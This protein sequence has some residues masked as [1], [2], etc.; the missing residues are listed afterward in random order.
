[1]FFNPLL[2][3]VLFVWQSLRLS[4]VV[5]ITYCRVSNEHVVYISLY[6]VIGSIA[7]WHIIEYIQYYIDLVK[8]YIEQTLLTIYMSFSLII[9]N[10][11]K[12]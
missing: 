2:C 1:M 11:L 5:F 3:A 9:G 12:T 7:V 10:L 8:K 4:L 6:S